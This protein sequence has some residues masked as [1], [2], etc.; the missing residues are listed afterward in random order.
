MDRFHR[1]GHRLCIFLF[2]KAGKF[3]TSMAQVP[4]NKLLTNLASS[5]RTGECWPSVVIVRTSLRLLCTAT[6]SGQSF[7]VRSSRTVSKRLIL[8]PNFQNGACCK[9]DLKDNKHNSLYLEQ[10][11]A[12]IFGHYLFLKA[13]SF[14]PA[15]LLE[16][17]YR[18]M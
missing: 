9:K 12:R 15:T 4:Y 13:H 1:N 14:P 5:S 2:S 10:K 18:Y 8:F 6:T 7:P 16:N 11:Y 3:K 17:C